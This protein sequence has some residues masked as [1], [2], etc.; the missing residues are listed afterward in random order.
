M[1]Y[2]D[3]KATVHQPSV[4]SL[5]RQVDEVTEVMRDNVTKLRDREGKLDDLVEKG[6][7]LEER[8]SLCFVLALHYIMI[9]GYFTIG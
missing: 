5:R 4:S 3:Y 6:Q 7:E 2:C 9:F 8:V 1:F